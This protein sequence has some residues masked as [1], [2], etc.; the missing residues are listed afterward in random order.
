M[1]E[2]IKNFIEEYIYE[3]VGYSFIVFAAIMVAFV[4]WKGYPIVMW[5]IENIEL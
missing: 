5:I 3:I 2:K 4:V 1:K